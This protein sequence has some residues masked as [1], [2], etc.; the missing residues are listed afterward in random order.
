ML[1]IIS[2]PINSDKD[3]MGGQILVVNI[4]NTNIRF[5]VFDNGECNVSWVI[6]TKPYRTK[7]EYYSQF[8]L[9]YQTYQVKAGSFQKIIIG[10]VVPQITNIITSALRKIHNIE[11]IL[12]N[13][14][15]PSGVVH[16]SNQIGNRYLR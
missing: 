16:S 9:F 14:V 4:G 5:S 12:V 6:N 15:T 13:R 10:S 1:N 8:M 2:E 3:L 7:D 11:P